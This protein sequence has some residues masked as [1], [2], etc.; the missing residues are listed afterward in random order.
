MERHLHFCF[1]CAGGATRAP[2]NGVVGVDLGPCVVTVEPPQANLLGAS[3]TGLCLAATAYNLGVNA[4]FPQT[5]LQGFLIFPKTFELLLST[6]Y[7]K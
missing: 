2:R 3:E 5:G 6:D 1:S 4:F 7:Q